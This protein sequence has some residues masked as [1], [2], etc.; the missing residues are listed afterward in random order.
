MCAIG[1]SK[2]S[3]D[4]PIFVVDTNILIYAADADAPEHEVC[5][6]H[7]ET[8]RRRIAPWHVTWGIVYEFIRVVTHPNVFR[9]PWTS[10][11]AW[12]FLS[13]I[14]VSPGLTALIETDHHHQVSV[15]VFNEVSH[16]SGNLVFDAHTAILMREHGIRTIYTRDTDFNRFPFVDVID[17]EQKER[18][19]SGR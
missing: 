5:R 12:S 6:E 19:T 7:V 2:A 8:W 1:R 11:E 3:G 9:S 13:A 4:G 17:P 14:L 16:L 15:A 10:Q 18:R